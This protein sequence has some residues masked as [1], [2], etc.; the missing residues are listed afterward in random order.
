M[1]TEQITF[2]VKLAESLETFS[3]NGKRIMGYHYF[4]KED[5][6]G[7]LFTWIDADTSLPWLKEKLEQKRI[8]IFND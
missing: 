3:H 1:Q 7:W 2:N 5:D 4:I 6:G 8:Y